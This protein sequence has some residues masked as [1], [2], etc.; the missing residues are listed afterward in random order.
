MYAAEGIAIRSNTLLLCREL[1]GRFARATDREVSQL[2]VRT[3]HGEAFPFWYLVNGPLADALTHIGQVNSW[4]RMAGKPVPPADLFRGLPP[5]DPR[6][7][8]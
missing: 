6:P 2:T 1:S 4:R 8:R 7:R 3:S 5:G